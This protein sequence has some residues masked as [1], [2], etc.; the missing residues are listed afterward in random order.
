MLTKQQLLSP[1]V[2]CIGGEQGKPNY[3][4]S[5][6]KTGEILT[7]EKRYNDVY[8]TDNNRSYIF[9]WHADRFPHLFK[10]LQ[11]WYG[12]TVE[13]MPEYILASKTYGIVKV[14]EWRCMGELC[15]ALTDDGMLS[16]ANWEFEPADESDYELYVS[17]IFTDK[18]VELSKEKNRLE[19]TIGKGVTLEKGGFAS[20][21]IDEIE[22]EITQLKDQYKK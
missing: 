10:P 8:L 1:R 12:R 13:E 2:L 5:Q 9:C 15:L 6:F 22:K 21:R 16:A 17:K 19:M 11:W 7:K 20:D 3:T 14:N 18:I 4:G